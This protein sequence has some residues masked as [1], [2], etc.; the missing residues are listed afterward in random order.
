MNILEAIKEYE[1]GKIVNLTK[2]NGDNVFISH[3]YRLFSLEDIKSN[4]WEI[5]KTKKEGWINI[6]RTNLTQ[7]M[8]E[9]YKT[10]EDANKK[11]CINFYIDTIKIE[12]EE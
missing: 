5:V 11:K 1:S 3:K 2:E 6:Y 8:V 7:Y 10:K 4:N 9:V 12:W